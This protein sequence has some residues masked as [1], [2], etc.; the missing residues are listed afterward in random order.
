LNHCSNRITG[1]LVHCDEWS[2][3]SSGRKFEVFHSRLSIFA[4]STS[5]SPLANEISDL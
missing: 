2:G 3:Q 5:P 1:K 4:K